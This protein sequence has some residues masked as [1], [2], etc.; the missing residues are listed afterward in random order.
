MEGRKKEGGREMGW[1]GWSAVEKG[2]VLV[3]RPLETREFPVIDRFNV[4]FF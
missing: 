4:F 3:C 1:E 2:L